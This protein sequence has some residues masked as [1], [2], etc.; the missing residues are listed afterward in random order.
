MY[1][2]Q[3]RNEALRLVESGLTPSAVSRQ[4]GGHPSE[5]TIKNWMAGRIPTGKRSKR[6][7]IPAERKVEAINRLFMGENYIDVATEIGCA[8]ESLLTW[9][10]EYLR[11]GIDAIKTPRD[12]REEINRKMRERLE[13]QGIANHG[14]EQA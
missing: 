9:R 14:R 13:R 10:R 2:E 1:S 6:C 4:L 12:V 8:P 5:T 3:V 11:G 7:Y